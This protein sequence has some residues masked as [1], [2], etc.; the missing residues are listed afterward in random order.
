[1]AQVGDEDYIFTD[2]KNKIRVEIDDEWCGLTIGERD[3]VRIYG[4]VDRDDK[5]S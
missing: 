1:M 5:F 3:L 2:G 4:E